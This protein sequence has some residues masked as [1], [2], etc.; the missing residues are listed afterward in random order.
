MSGHSRPGETSRVTRNDI[1]SA[2]VDLQS[3]LVSTVESRRR[4]LTVVG[5]VAALAILVVAYAFGR[6]S[7][8]RLSGI[9]EIRR[10]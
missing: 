2:L 4:S 3:D 9:V 6:R 1:E 7:A 10:R 5:V 8:R